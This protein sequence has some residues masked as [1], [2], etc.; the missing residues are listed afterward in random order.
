MTR[1][2]L[3]ALA[4]ASLTALVTPTLASSQNGSIDF[5]YVDPLTGVVDLGA[6][7]GDALFELPSTAIFFAEM[8]MRLNGATAGGI[9]GVEGFI[10]GI[11]AT[12]WEAVFVPVTGTFPVGSFTQ[13]HDRDGDTVADTRRGNIVFANIF[14][15]NPEEGCQA[16]N[17]IQLKLGELHLFQ[18]PV[19]APIPN[20]TWLCFLAGNPSSNPS[21]PCLLV[22]LCDA[23]V[24]TAVCVTGGAFI[25]NPVELSCT[26]SQRTPRA[27]SACFATLAVAERTWSFVKTLYR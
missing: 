20:D 12:G 17:G 27:Q 3:A 19:A 24:Y 18:S 1:R 2:V 26:A 9:S 4:F 21:F 11:E 5:F 25:I 22:T 15:P 16:G 8:W 10:G 6:C 13:A 14:G 23:P 7:Q